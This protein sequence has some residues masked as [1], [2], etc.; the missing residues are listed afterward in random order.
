M[1]MKKIN[2]KGAEIFVP[3]SEPNPRHAQ[4]ERGVAAWVGDGQVRMGTHDIFAGPKYKQRDLEDYWLDEA[5]ESE[6]AGLLDCEDGDRKPVTPVEGPSGQKRRPRSYY[7]KK[8]REYAGYLAQV[9]AGVQP[10]TVHVIDLEQEPSAERVIGGR[11]T[12]AQMA[13]E[14]NKDS[15]PPPPVFELDYGLILDALIK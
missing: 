6:A 5:D 15:G 1:N 14:S 10:S 2:W 9:A 7:R 3:V 12:R 8:E 13:E 11:P 4:G